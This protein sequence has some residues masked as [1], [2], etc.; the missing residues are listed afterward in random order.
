MSDITPA[1]E[2]TDLGLIPSSEVK[3]DDVGALS[4]RYVD[5]VPVL[6]VTGGAVGSPCRA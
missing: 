6:V 2:V 1:P 3:P 5:G 4:V